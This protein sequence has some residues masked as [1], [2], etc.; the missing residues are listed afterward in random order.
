MIP[1]DA[2]FREMTTLKHSYEKYHSRH[3]SPFHPDLPIEE[4]TDLNEYTYFVAKQYDQVPRFTDKV[5]IVNYHDNDLISNLY[6]HVL[7]HATNACEITFQRESNEQTVPKPTVI[8]QDQAYEELALGAYMRGRFHAPDAG[9][10][11]FHGQVKHWSRMIRSR[12]ED[13]SFLFEDLPIECL[14]DFEV[15]RLLQVSLAY[16]KSLL[17]EFFS[18]AKGEAELRRDFASRQFCSVD[19]A[20]VLQRTQWNFLFEHDEGETLLKAYVHIGGPNTNSSAIQLALIQDKELLA[21]D[22]YFLAIH[23]ANR[24]SKDDPYIIDNML[25]ESDLIGPCLWDQEE[26]DHVALTN[27]EASVCQPGMLP[28]FRKFIDEAESQRKNVLISNE[29]LSRVSSE[30]GLDKIFHEYSWDVNIIIYYRRY[31]EWL[32]AMYDDWRSSI[33][34]DTVHEMDGKVRFIDF[35]RIVNGRLFMAGDIGVHNDQYSNSFVDLVDVQEYTYQ[36]WRQFRSIDRFQ[37]SVHI[38]DY[39]HHVGRNQQRNSRLYCDVLV[40]AGHACNST[41]F[42]FANQEPYHFVEDSHPRNMIGAAASLTQTGQYHKQ[43]EQSIQD[44]VIGAFYDGAMH[45]FVPNDP[46]VVETLDDVFLEYWTDVVRYNMDRHGLCLTDLPMDCLDETELDLLQDVSLAYE[47]LLM[48]TKYK[49]G[50]AK[51]LVKEFAIYRTEHRFCSLDVE[52]IV[53]SYG[54]ILFSTRHQT[55][56]QKQRYA[57]DRRRLIDSSAV[58]QQRQDQQLQ[59]TSMFDDTESDDNF[60]P[61]VGFF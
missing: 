11:G 17:P 51:S 29:W 27:K 14:E 54:A 61:S 15:H 21:E 19:V 5:H 43:E 49:N 26:R 1:D 40:D 16:E 4:L 25:Y 24:P 46:D 55:Q 2:P 23:G 58:Q 53:D 42:D 3:S 50:G 59:E 18:S 12:L 13:S 30:S 44:I 8:D 41:R 47:R 28:R 56:D 10:S 6:C 60:V 52:S 22:G 57:D 45:Y 20:E 39:H 35:A 31:F 33:S 32:C 36:L 7:S 38:V 34:T 37:T 48:P 9:S